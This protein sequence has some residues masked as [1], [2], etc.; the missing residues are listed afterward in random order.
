MSMT[1]FL[2]SLLI[3]GSLCIFASGCA[4]PSLDQRSASSA[5]PEAEASNTLLGLAI[6]PQLAKQQGK[7]GTY[8]LG[9]PLNAFA[10][11]MLLAKTAERTLDIQYYIWTKDV[12]G[13]LLLE[14]LREAAAR[15]VRVRLLLD[16]N[17]TAGLDKELAALAAI[18]NFEIRLFNPF[19]LRQ[20]KWLGFIT[21]FERSNRRMHNK[22]FTADNR[23]TI[24]GGRNI[25]DDYFGATSGALKADL[26]AL[27]VGPVVQ[28]VSEDFD[29]YWTS[30]SA[31]PVELIVRP[32]RPDSV[33]ITPLTPLSTASTAERDNYLTAVSNSTFV[34]DL[35]QGQLPMV[36]APAKM[37]SDDPAKGLSRVEEEELLIHAMAEVIGQPQHSLVLVSPYF[38]PT[39]A[40]VK[41]FSRLARQGLSVSILT[42]AMEATDVLP[43]H[44]GY[45]KHRKA[46]L[47][48]GIRLYE[49]RQLAGHSGRHSK[50]CPFGSSSSSLHA[51]TFAVDR[52]RIFIGSF[53]FDPRSMHLNTELGFVIESPEIASELEDQ[54]KAEVLH[55]A[56]QVS[57]NEA[58]KLQ[59][60]DRHSGEEI[61]YSTEPG[62]TAVKRAA[63]WLLSKLPIEW[64]L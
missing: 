29:R 33:D 37:I 52:S 59:W 45:A 6:A 60:I 7:S 50:A 27:L 9:N 39:E 38:V 64:M 48:A 36:W 43:V 63:L 41:A 42:N 55:S 19:I 3:V 23:A 31:Y 22:S 17:G 35:L 26:D 2:R 49:L 28:D 1:T 47:K 57:L 15:G 32:H 30:Q 46:L 25:G 24:I 11:R 53:N 56:Y 34:R 44:A 14:A 61:I 40:G 51:K 58:G 18:P 21:D 5:L 62:S 54:F 10:A 20:A 16:D 12:T 13:R 4:L 8:P